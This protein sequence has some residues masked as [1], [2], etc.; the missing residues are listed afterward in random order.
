MQHLLRK[1]R[2]EIKR[3]RK[4]NHK[5]IT[6]PSLLRIR[7]FIPVDTIRE[8]ENFLQMNPT[9]LRDSNNFRERFKYYCRSLH[10]FGPGMVWYQD[11]T[12][13]TL[14]V[15]YQDSFFNFSTLF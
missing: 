9:V 1:K 8:P 11:A 7:W 2:E 14:Q 4:K 3:K 12:D 5:Y 13:P 6:I 15:P 10:Q